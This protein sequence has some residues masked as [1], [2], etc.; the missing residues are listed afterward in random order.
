MYAGLSQKASVLEEALGKTDSLRFFIQIM[1][2]TKLIA[3][4]Q[5]TSLGTEIETIGKMIGGWRKGLLT[6]T[7]ATKAGE[8]K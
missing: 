3:N 7:P 1:W 8:R 6:K 2:E 5:F 4:T